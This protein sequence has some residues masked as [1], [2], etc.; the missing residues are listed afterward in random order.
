MTPIDPLFDALAD[1]IAARIIAAM[2]AMKDS[3][4][5]GSEPDRLLTLDDAARQLGVKT[6]WLQRHARSLPFARRLGH[7][8]LR[9]SARGIERW[10]ARRTG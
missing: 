3:T 6:T 4:P 10:L 2:T 9:F 7:R 5:A 1:R 8:T